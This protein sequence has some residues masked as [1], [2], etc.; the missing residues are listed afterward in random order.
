M[1]SSMPEPVNSIEDQRLAVIEQTYPAWR[2]RKRPNDM[3]TATRV[4]APSATQASAGFQQCI[5]QPGLD[6]LAAALGQ[7]LYIAQTTG[8][9]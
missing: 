6:A 8:H 9:C 2:I 5:L 3:W 1:T 7:Q 4:R